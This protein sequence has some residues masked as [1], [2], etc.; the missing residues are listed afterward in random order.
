MPVA[1][2]DCCENAHLM[3]NFLATQNTC[4][5][6]PSPWVALL[7]LV[8]YLLL[9]EYTNTS[10]EEQNISCPK[11]NNIFIADNIVLKYRVILLAFVPC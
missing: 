5:L 3:K 11:K 10:V 6:A 2:H 8:K 1:Q 4:I 7:N 9:W